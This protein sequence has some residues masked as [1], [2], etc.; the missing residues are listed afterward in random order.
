M[1]RADGLEVG[2]EVRFSG[3]GHVVVER[4]W[5]PEATGRRLPDLLDLLRQRESWVLRDPETGEGR[6]VLLASLTER[7]RANLLRWLE[8][9]AAQ[10]HSAQEHS[11][12]RLSYTVTAEM[13]SDDLDRAL[14]Q[15]AE[16]DPLAWLRETPLYQTLA[17]TTGYRWSW[18]HR[19]TQPVV[20]LL[21]PAGTAS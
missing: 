21:A 19:A 13:A 11:L 1:A 17:A 20:D 18:L 3:T 5:I 10:L 16:E 4:L 12:L 9:K 6:L 7:H 15:M 14:E 2:R 8:R